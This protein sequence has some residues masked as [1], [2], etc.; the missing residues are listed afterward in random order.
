MVLKHILG[1][2]L[3]ARSIGWAYVVEGNSPNTSDV[4][5]M[6]VRVNPLSTDEQ[7]DFEKGKPLTTNASRTLRRS[8][9]RN[10]DRYQLRRKHLIKVLVDNNIIDDSAVLTENGKHTTFDTW[11]L[12]AKSANER[13]ELY[14]LARV[15]LAINKKRGY[16]SSRKAKN[17]EDG[18]LVDGMAIAKELYERKVTPGQFVYQNYLRGK[19]VVPDFY[20]SDL[21]HEF[22]RIWE[23]QKQF[24]PQFLSDELRDAIIGQGK[25]NTSRRIFAITK[26][27]TAEI[28]DFEK[29]FKNKF[30]DKFDKRTLKKIQS[31][32]W[33]S[34]SL[35]V[36]LGL[37]E[38][39]HVLAEVNNNLSNSSGYL[40]AISDRSKKLYFNN[41]TVGQFLFKQL[42]ENPHNSLRNQVFYRE[43]YLDEFE[44]VWETQ[45][46][47]YPVLTN[48]LKEEIRDIIIFYQRPLK[49]QK[50]LVSFCQL[51]SSTRIIGGKKK[52]IGSKVAPKSSPLFQEF[53]I[54]QNL[55]NLVFKGKGNSEGELFHLDYDCKKVLFD[56]LNVKGKLTATQ[57]IGLLGYKPKD[58]ELNYD[59]IE[60][61]ETNQALYT[62]FLKI[63]E[64]ENF[65]LDLLKLPEGDVIDVSKV[66]IPVGELKKLIE[67][68]F[69][70]L[71]INSEI[72]KFDAT[73]DG[74]EF[75]RQP[76]YQLWLLLYSAE[77]D[78]GKQSEEDLALYG[79]NNI[80]LKKKLCEKFGFKPEHSKVLANVVF[81][82]EYASLSAKAMRKIYPHIIENKYSKA[83]E[84]AN[85]NHSKNSI[86]KEENESRVLKPRLELLNK[87]S[88]RNPV[89]EKIL[90]QMINVIN[91][92]IDQEN[93]KLEKEGKDRDFKFDEIRIE[94]ARELKKSAKERAEMTL[95]ISAATRLNEKVRK[96]LESEFNIPNPTRNDII[97]YKLYMELEKNGFKDLYTNIYIP[98]EKLFTK[99][100]DIDHIIPRA[101]LFDD[102]F[103][104]KTIVY[105]KENLKKGNRTAVD[106]IASEYGATSL[107]E[108]EV[109]LEDLYKNKSIN[110]AKYQKLLKSAT[111]IGDGFIHRDLKESQ[112]IAKKAKEILLEIT[113]VVTSTSGRITDRLRD[114]WGLINV[115]KEINLPK[116]SKLG[117]TEIEER[118]YGQ[119][120][121]V[122]KGWTKRNDHRH[123]ALDAL[124]IAFTKRSY[125]QYLNN[126]NARYSDSDEASTRVRNSNGKLRF[127]SDLKF[128]TID[129]KGIERKEL[130]KDIDGK[131][132]FNLPMPNFR[133]IAKTHLESIIVSHKNK[134]KVVTKN[135]NVIKTNNGAKSKEELT[136]RG[137]L[138]EETI[139]SKYHYYKK[140]TEKVGAK[141]DHETITKVASPV[142][143]G[144]LLKRLKDNGGDPRKAFSG[145]NSLIKKPIYL[146][147][148]KT[149][150][151]PDKVDLIWLE[152]GFSTRKEVNPTNFKDEKAINKVLDEGVKRILMAR[153]NEFE[154]DAKKAFSDLENNPIWLSKEHSIPIKR[155]AVSGIRKADSLR[156]KKDNSG[157]A[158]L[159]KMGN[160]IPIDFVNTGN[161]H[162]VAVYKVPLLNKAGLPVLDSNSNPQFIIQE[163]IVSFFE[164]VERVRQNLPEVN[165]S[166]NKDVGWEFLYTMKRNEL[167]VFPNK[168]TG[169]DPYEIDLLDPSNKK[170]ISPNLFRVQKLSERNYV[171][172]HH[173]ETSVAESSTVLRNV[174]WRDFRS[175]KGLEEI[176]KVRVN[177]LGDIVH[178]GEF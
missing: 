7:L 88:L 141:F 35:D 147:S 128:S 82:N 135:I 71:G 153:L 97:R 174:T 75:E 50:G 12:R 30:A 167:F 175:T 113:R 52:N 45:A 121:E 131:F 74:N 159:D 5:Q 160:K 157:D 92:L 57:V 114:D 60:G 4:K 120:I 32:K 130:Y 39:A 20:R 138:H 156:V 152:E 90:N 36:K 111:E 140:K 34:E 127:G 86:T 51:E 178:V 78:N 22:D 115:M 59:S 55:N 148:E 33:R 6:G 102:S 149:K 73:L 101:R 137:Q 139:Y 124:T 155:V 104:N 15:L 154:N 91:T 1:L 80:S 25:R 17:D 93:D 105:R 164:V 126:L 72:L 96:I 63:L 158:I 122:I 87:N 161:N 166:L 107:K 162:H 133:Q 10:L 151:C 53:K 69:E 49:S 14:E 29:N 62:A 176:V 31:Y 24:H 28:K 125:I 129:V 110:K 16:K 132:K 143:R 81:E 48:S 134:N 41:E 108:Y 165:K 117:L 54:W 70:T 77:D 65:N 144:L 173:L 2:D 18:N 100:I 64:N 103:S 170:D 21:Q 171:F 56:E 98:K 26:V 27:N 9:R 146:D 163:V 172:R 145:K 85:Y 23:F 118:K 83:C 89:V 68:A 43:D 40:G 46:K 67:D 37:E 112:Y 95:G 44:K 11:R 47:Y 109:R 19:K 116:Y 106:Y 79:H 84:L 8:A 99:E 66:K 123:H 13:V 150:I 61:N 177:H 142:I 58:W 136:P 94:L 38:L 3:G 169:F 168:E 42:E 119:K 76:L